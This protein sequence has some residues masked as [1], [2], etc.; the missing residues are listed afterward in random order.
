MKSIAEIKSYPKLT[1]VEAWQMD[2]NSKD[3]SL[4]RCWSQEKPSKDP[5]YE[6]FYTQECL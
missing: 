1:E 6:S 2:C 5:A 4:S 3:K